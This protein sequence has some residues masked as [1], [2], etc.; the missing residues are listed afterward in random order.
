MNGE[1]IEAKTR[2]VDWSEVDEDTFVRL[3]EFAY[4]RNYTPPTFRLVDGMFP[5]EGTK[6]AKG[7]SKH[8]KRRLNAN[9]D[10]APKPEPEPEPQTDLA[11]APDE[12]PA[13]KH[14]ICNDAEIPYAERSIW[15]KQLRGAFDRTLIVPRRQSQSDDL[16]YAYTPPRN[17]GPWEDFNPVFIDQARLYVLADKYGI[18]SLRRL[19]LSKLQET[20]RSFKLYDAGV[21]GIIEFVRFVYSN[22]PPNHGNRMDPMRNLVTRYIV[23]VLGQIGKNES[24]QQ[25]LADGGPF[26][27]DFWPI[28]WSTDETDSGSS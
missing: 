2:H 16:G 25:L 26:V 19:I 1:M 22:T 15:T 23:S 17:T 14:T 18:E 3:C 28:I 27:S 12:S 11:I 20:L 10:A 6:L 24:F 7:K 21:T 13:S 4:F 9:S 5:A 8:K